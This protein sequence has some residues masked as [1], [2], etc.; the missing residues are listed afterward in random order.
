MNSCCD[1]PIIW[2]EKGNEDVIS[3]CNA[4]SAYVGMEMDGACIAAVGLAKMSERRNNR[5]V[6]GSLSGYPYFCIK[7]PGL[8]SGLMIPQ[9]V[10][11]GL[12][13][14]MRMLATPSTIDNTPTCGNQEDY[15]AMG[16]N[17]CKK[18]GPMAEKLEYMLA[19]ELLSV[20][21]VQQ[22][23]DPDVSRAPATT[24]VL[25]EISRH[26]PVMEKDMLL[27]PYIEYLKDFIH[28]GEL[29]RVAEQ[30]TGALS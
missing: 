14:E 5:I 17:A 2:P 4:D 27:H 23:V 30:V 10:Q 12:L 25:A 13:N 24:A 8:N 19:I 6:D 18:S 15:V 22:F 28:S 1:N 20:Y 16:Y 21:Q 29:I 3:A 9:Y 11:A 7:N 26:V